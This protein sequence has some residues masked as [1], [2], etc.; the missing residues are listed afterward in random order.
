MFAIQSISFLF[1]ATN[2]NVVKYGHVHCVI[3]EMETQYVMSFL[4]TMLMTTLHLMHK[5]GVTPMTN[6]PPFILV[7]CCGR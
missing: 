7:I 2:D 4:E 6:I 1:K 5:I 3:L